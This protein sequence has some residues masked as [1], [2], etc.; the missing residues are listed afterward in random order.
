[1]ISSILIDQLQLLEDR[2][3]AERFS[4][5]KIALFDL[6]NT[7]IIG[8]IGEA[9]FAQLLAGKFPL[10]LQWDEYQALLRQDRKEAYQRVVKAMNGIT[11]RD[12]EDATIKII[13]SRELF[14]RIEDAQVPVPRPHPKMKLLVS[15]LQDLGYDIYIISAS[16]QISVRMIA[17]T[18]FEISPQCA[19]GIQSV[20]SKGMLTEKLADPIPIWRG[21]VDTYYKYIDATQPL[22]TASDS[23]MDVPLFSLTDPI[24]L[25]LWVGNDYHLF[26]TMQQSIRQPQRFFFVK[27]GEQSKF[28]KQCAQIMFAAQVR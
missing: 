18:F 26:E 27:R 14:I 21:K 3:N 22:I 4:M 7:L 25:S 12:V 5:K 20:V 11:Y 19:F 13:E 1:M 17:T 28:E 9:V 2:A 6:D 24:G 16:N 8:D 23:F 15:L 10:S